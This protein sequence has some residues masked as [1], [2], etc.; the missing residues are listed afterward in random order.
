MEFFEIN[1]NDRPHPGEYLL[2]APSKKIVVCGAFK[3][4]EG[5][6]KVLSDGRLFEDAIVNF[7][8]IKL[9][10]AEKKSRRPSRCGG[11]KK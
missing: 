11:C 2:H 4:A 1:E 5:K 8:K 10:I 6:I 7:Q 9:T 3:P